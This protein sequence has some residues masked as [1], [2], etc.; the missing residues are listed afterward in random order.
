MSVVREPVCALVVTKHNFLFHSV[1]IKILIQ[2]L[3][4]VSFM[5]S[6]FDNWLLFPTLFLEFY[7]V[8]FC[9]VPA[10]I[11]TNLLKS[12]HSILHFPAFIFGCRVNIR[13]QTDLCSK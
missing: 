2:F 1:V 6:M 11:R 3:C 12:F 13:T 7:A 10:V 8:L 9:V 5:F 4:P